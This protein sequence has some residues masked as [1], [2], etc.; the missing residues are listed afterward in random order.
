L[1][2]CISSL[3]HLRKIVEMQPTALFLRLTVEESMALRERALKEGV[4]QSSM[5]R[6][7]LHAYGIAPKQLPARSGYDIIRDIVGQYRGD[8]KDLSSNPRYITGYGNF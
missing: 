7:A 6:R 5:V 8:P 2:C 4:S 1:A 3:H